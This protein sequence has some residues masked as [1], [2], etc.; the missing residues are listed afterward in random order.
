VILSVKR[1]KNFPASFKAFYLT[2]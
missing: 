1:L 2:I